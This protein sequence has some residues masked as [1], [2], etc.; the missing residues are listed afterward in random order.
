[1]KLNYNDAVNFRN[2]ALEKVQ[3]PRTALECIELTKILMHKAVDN[4]EEI[5]QQLEFP[6]RYSELAIQRTFKFLFGIPA[7]QVSIVPK[8]NSDQKL[9]ILNLK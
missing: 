1:M 6:N 3:P 8:V 7:D 2:T 5:P 9:C 4:E